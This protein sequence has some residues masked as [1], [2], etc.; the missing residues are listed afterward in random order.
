MAQDRT[1]S[2]EDLQTVKDCLRRLR[3]TKRRVTAAAVLKQLKKA[4]GVEISL[5]DSIA[6]PDINEA[7]KELQHIFQ[8]RVSKPKGKGQRKRE[9]AQRRREERLK[10]R[11]P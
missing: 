11:K 10:R 1:L 8:P 4:T 9:G 2:D 5:Q 6:V 7:L 3:S